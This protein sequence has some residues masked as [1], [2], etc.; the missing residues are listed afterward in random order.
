MVLQGERDVPVAT[1]S[2]DSSDIKKDAVLDL[3]VV[4][5]LFV[6][7]WCVWWCEFIEWAYVCM[8]RYYSYTQTR[9]FQKNTMHVHVMK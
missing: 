6:H 2:E 1:E 4:V 7:V 5:G 8:N 3:C 9:G